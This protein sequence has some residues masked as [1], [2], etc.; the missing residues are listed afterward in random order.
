MTCSGVLSVGETEA[1]LLTAAPGVMAS[2]MGDQ[3][4]VVAGRSQAANMI[5]LNRIRRV[6]FMV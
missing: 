5:Q 6:R 1:V 4:E 2:L 3:L